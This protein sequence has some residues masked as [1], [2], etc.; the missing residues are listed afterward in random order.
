MLARPATVPVALAGWNNTFSPEVLI[1]TRAPSAATVGSGACLSLF[2]SW[3]KTPRLVTLPSLLS[4]GVL[5]VPGFLLL[6]RTTAAGFRVVQ[7][8]RIRK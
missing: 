3:A 7:T 2:F 6:G 5:Y 1:S 4:P 8:L